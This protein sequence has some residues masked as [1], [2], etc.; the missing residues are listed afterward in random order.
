MHQKN[1]SAVRCAS[2]TMDFSSDI[3]PSCG[4]NDKIIKEVVMRR[5]HLWT[6]TFILVSAFVPLKAQEGLIKAF[7]LE[8]NP[9]TL[10]RLAKPGTPFDK[11]GRRFAILAD[12]SGSFEAWAYPLK[13]IRNFTFSFLVGSSTRPIQGKDI[14]RYITVAPEATILTY[15]Y[16][17]FTVKAIYIAPIEEPGAI[18]LLCV[19][20]NLPLTIVCGFLPVLQPMWPAGLGGQFAVWNEEQN[21]YIIS[22]SKGQNHGIIGS[23]AA[24]GI[25]YTPA[26]MLS[27]VPNEF[28]I[29]I[30]DPNK[31]KNKYIPI[32]IAGGKGKREQ[33][34]N[35]YTKLKNDPE[36]YYRDNLAHYQSLRTNTLQVKTPY[37][38]LNLAYEWAKVAY[39]NLMVDNPD[40][41]KGLIAGLGASGTSGRPGF[42]WFFG[43]DA[44][45]NSFSLLSLGSHESAR[46]AL[47]FTQKWQRKDGKMPHE[48]SQAAAYIDWWN[49]YHYGYIHGDTTPYYI[50]AVYEYVKKTGDTEFVKKSWESLKR[51]FDWCMST[52]VDNDGLMNNRQA[53]LGALEY[54]ALTGIETDIYLSG[55]W[56][57]AAY[58][59]QH[60]AQLAGDKAAASK[61]GDL[62]KKAQ[63]T[64]DKKFWDEENQFYAY[65]FNSEGATVKEI[66]PWNAIGLMWNLGS[67][68][69]SLH[70]L[71][72]ISSA[73]LTTDWGTRSISIKSK[74]FQPLNYNYGAV[75]PF[76]T[77]W[78]TAALYR[79]HMPLQGYSLLMSTAAHTYDN[80]LGC[81]TEVFSG[82]NNIWP[83][84]AVPHQGFSTA[85]VVL[86]L[87]RGLL[88]L[89]GD[90]LN[91]SLIFSPHF[92]ADWKQVSIENY[93][94]GQANF[95]FEYERGKDKINAKV[96]SESA[97]GYTLRFSPALGI[98]TRILSLHVNGEPVA[99]E[100]KERAQVVQVESEISVQE[101]PLFIE[102]TFIPTVEILPFVPKSRIG[103]SNKGLKI[104][105]LKNESS[106]L[107]LLVEGLCNETYH[108]KVTMPQRMA[109]V[110]GADVKEDELL[111]TM[112]EGKL[113]NFVSKKIAIY[114]QQKNK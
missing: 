57:R 97:Q 5:F 3:S 20:S 22:E 83:Q 53:G 6:M 77:S 100:A 49:D 15:T 92:P 41:G 33:V 48:L 52:D 78:V 40:L 61:A 107:I 2:L 27:D 108:M 89:E 45:I 109:K 8:P 73:E 60:L 113:G 94:V 104:I 17:S 103:D 58:A 31:V 1:I 80:S 90:A 85:G 74:Y 9:I 87:I 68:E 105:S 101:D 69:R 34:L 71:E 30:P 62:F 21:A 55:V 35:V 95:T 59:M 29:E 46:D 75:W 44:Y 66:S 63:R 47:I 65:A 70:S 112:P 67:E 72:K 16:Q 23:P 37:P 42:G 91:R 25:S 64:F 106:K 50:A 81:I 38:K 93:R 110:E 111:F 26:H 24:L 79:H 32:I 96:H 51:A 102:M 99:F 114:L 36:K 14:V 43:G 82:T 84:E 39:D 18:I 56:L 4:E 88:G 19:D 98:G 7:R 13:L 76:L 12:E 10:K 28:N 11:V 86:P 54:G